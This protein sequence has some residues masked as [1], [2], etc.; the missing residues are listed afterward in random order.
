MTGE[1]IDLNVEEPALTS[2]QMAAEI[3][4]SRASTRRIVSGALTCKR[5][6]SRYRVP[7]RS[8]MKSERGTVSPPNVMSR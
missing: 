8:R 6:G 2:A 4:V 1:V 5:V 7:G 3:G